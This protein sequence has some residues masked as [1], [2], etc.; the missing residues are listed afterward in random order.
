M[1]SIDHSTIDGIR[2]GLQRNHSRHSV[3]TITQITANTDGVLVQYV[4]SST[5]RV[6]WFTW[7]RI[8]DEALPAWDYMMRA[9]D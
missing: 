3:I 2:A 1:T 9:G 6:A 8:R 7:Q 5:N 4:E